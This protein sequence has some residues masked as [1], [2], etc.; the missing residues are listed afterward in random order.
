VGTETTP[1]IALNEFVAANGHWPIHSNDLK[2][3]VKR[4]SIKAYL[5]AIRDADEF[6]KR[7]SVESAGRSAIQF[8][9]LTLLTHCG[10]C[11]KLP[12]RIIILFLYPSI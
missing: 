4:I 9:V 11:G 2:Q 7:S 10:H 8:V 5:S 6:L 12:N 1:G 3:T